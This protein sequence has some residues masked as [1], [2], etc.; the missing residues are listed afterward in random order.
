MLTK[1]LWNFLNIQWHPVDDQ[2]GITTAL[3]RSSLC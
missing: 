3:T 2:P 1:H